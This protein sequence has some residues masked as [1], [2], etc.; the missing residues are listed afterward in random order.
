MGTRRPTMVISDIIEKYWERHRNEAVM[1]LSGGG[2]Y[3][4]ERSSKLREDWSKT[5]LPHQRG[6]GG[7]KTTA[8]WMPQGGLCTHPTQYARL[9][10]CSWR[11]RPPNI[12]S[13]LARPTHALCAPVLM[14]TL[15]SRHVQEPLEDG[16]MS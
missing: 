16:R 10:P 1:G 15:V 7:V 3:P 9:A 2:C 13:V 4:T 11:V 14:R 6:G 12:I 8:A 5:P